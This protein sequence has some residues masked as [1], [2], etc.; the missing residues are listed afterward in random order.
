MSHAA[1]LA[2]FAGA[3]PL[4]E[5]EHL[6]PHRQ[7]E[8][9]MGGL[10]S[11]IAG[12]RHALRQTKP[13]ARREDADRA[14]AILAYLRTILDPKAD[15]KLVGQLDSLYRYCEGRILIA[16]AERNEAALLEV[17]G[18]IT[19]IKQ[20]WEAIAPQPAVAA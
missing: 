10:L 16:C 17:A 19:S 11:R 2:A 8:L 12:L 3:G 4:A 14:L 18:L 13:Q 6:G 7:I 20:A 1:Q 15:P 5:M 9:L